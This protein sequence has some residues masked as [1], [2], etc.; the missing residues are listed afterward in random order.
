MIYTF[1]NKKE[2][3][4][5]IGIGSTTTI[6]GKGRKIW[7]TLEIIVYSVGECYTATTLLISIGHRF[8]IIITIN[9]R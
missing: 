8:N 1:Q 2:Y 6:L 9:N 5:D 3:S 7:M 4:D